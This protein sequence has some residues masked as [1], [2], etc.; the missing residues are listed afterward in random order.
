[1]ST[2]ENEGIEGSLLR[3]RGPAAAI[4]NNLVGRL[5]IKLNMPLLKLDALED[6]LCCCCSFGK[7]NQ[8]LQLFYV[9]VGANYKSWK[10]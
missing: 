9:V 2:L 5:V 6:K 8:A 1:M 3:C 7:L 4:S 10:R